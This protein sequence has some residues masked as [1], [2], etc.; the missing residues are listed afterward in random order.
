VLIPLQGPAPK[1]GKESFLNV[2]YVL[3]ADTLWAKQGHAV[4]WEQIALPPAPEAPPA[5]LASLAPVDLQESSEAFTISGPGFS[6]AIGRAS[7]ALESLRSCNRELLA[8][9]LLPNFWRVPLDN[10]IGFLLLNDMPKRCAVWKTAGPERRVTAVR[11]ERIA[12]QAVRVT[13]ESVLPAASS[14]YATSYT[15][16]GTGDVLVEA[17]FTPG[18]DLPE[19]TRF[20]MQTAVPAALRT[21]TWL[22]RGPHENYWDRNSGAP[23]GRYS[24]RVHELV[25]DYVRPPGERQPDRRAL[26]R[27]HRRGRRGP[28]RGGPSPPERERLALHDAGSGERHAHERAAT[29]RHDHAQPRLPA[30]G[31]GRRRRL[32]RP[33][34]R[35][36][37]ARPQA[38]RVPLPPTRVRPGHGPARRRRASP[39]ADAVATT[40]NDFSPSSPSVDD[41][42]GYAEHAAVAARADTLLLMPAG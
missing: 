21:M 8:K 6:V 30:D 27:A 38:V 17:R 41:F 7:G 10:D 13:A 26:D 3:K 15:V 5:A 37:H 42:V 33:P 29:P 24:G 9:P 16:Y 25:H 2:R 1:P 40:A 4:A 22:G 20:G 11:A 19:L 35:R 31:R 36:V 23:V 28:P 34:P 12:A 39:T 32:G 14:S 18:G